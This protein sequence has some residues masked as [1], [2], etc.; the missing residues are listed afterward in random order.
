MEK[1]EIIKIHKWLF[2]FLVAY[3]LIGIPTKYFVDVSYWFY[4]VW[5][6]FLASLSVVFCLW[7]R[8]FS[9]KNQ[10]KFEIIF[11]VLW[12]LFFPNAP[13]VITDLLHLRSAAGCYDVPNLLP[14]KCLIDWYIL[15][16]TFIGSFIGA[17]CTLSSLHNMH[18]F[19]L[20]EKKKYA[21]YLPIIMC[22]LGGIGVYIGRFVRLNSW[23]VFNPPKF[24]KMFADRGFSLFSLE[25]IGITTVTLLILYVIYYFLLKHKIIAFNKE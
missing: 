21:R 3:F 24:F 7:F 8:F 13:Y 6:V 11:A 4:M 20:K 10:R 25:F 1:K 18:C 9:G 23:D 14:Y 19:A 15:F 17:I 16:Y 2:V 22:L 5:N 12:V